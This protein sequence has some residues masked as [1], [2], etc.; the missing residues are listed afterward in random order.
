[1]FRRT[2]FVVVVVAMTTLVAGIPSHAVRPPLPTI[3]GATWETWSDPDL[4]CGVELT[5]TFQDVGRGRYVVEFTIHDATNDHTIWQSFVLP[6]GETSLTSD[7]LG[8]GLGTGPYTVDHGEVTLHKGGG[9]NVID[10]EV[11]PGTI[12]C[13]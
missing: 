1:M 5:A 13:P 3:T 9:A 6:E 8:A 12:S 7:P 11:I 10:S 2:I 4:G